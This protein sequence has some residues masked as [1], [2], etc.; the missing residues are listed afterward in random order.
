MKI[1]L[2]GLLCLNIQ[3]CTQVKSNQKEE[4]LLP[5]NQELTQQIILVETEGWNNF[6][7]SMTLLEKHENGWNEAGRFKAV[8]GKKGF[9]IGKGKTTQFDHNYIQKVEGDGKSPAGIFS[10]GQLMGYAP[11][12]DEYVHWDYRTLTKNDLGIDDPASLFYNQVIDTTEVKATDFKSFETMLRKDNQYK[13]LYEINHNREN[14]PG[15]GSLIFLHIWKNEKTG[16]AG[17][18]AI[19]EENFKILRHWLDQKKNPVII[20]GPKELKSHLLQDF[21]N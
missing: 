15:M 5:K 10:L 13:W 9:G 19:S 20:Q 18:T 12:T 8:I 16:T 3:A 17:C 1:L 14:I 6:K 21:I 4:A 2:M 7:A 11:E